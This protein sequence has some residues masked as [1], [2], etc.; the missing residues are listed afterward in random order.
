MQQVAASLLAATHGT[1]DDRHVSVLPLSTLLE[2]LA[3]VYVPL[4]AG[5]SCHLLPL[6]EVGLSGSTGLDVKKCWPR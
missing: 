5:A 3:G 4:L 2:N 1:A 6:A